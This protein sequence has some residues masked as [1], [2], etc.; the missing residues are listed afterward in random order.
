MMTTRWN[1]RIHTV[2]G[3]TRWWVKAGRIHSLSPDLGP[4]WV[5]NF[6]PEVFQM[7]PD[8]QLAPRGTPGAVEVLRVELVAASPD[9]GSMA[10]GPS[11][12]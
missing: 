10:A 6:K 2:A 1:I 3:D 11:P 9:A 12:A 8:G 4:V 5:A 7:L